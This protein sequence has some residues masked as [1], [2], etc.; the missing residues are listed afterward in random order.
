VDA[1][2]EFLEGHNG[3]VVADERDPAVYWITLHPQSDPE[4]T[5]VARLVWT[6]YPHSAPSVLFASSVGGEVGQARYWPIVPGYRPPNDICMPFTA[7]GLGLHT[8][9]SSGPQAW[10]VQGNPFVRVAQQLQDDLDN[11]YGGRAG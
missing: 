3:S 9:W 6:R 4:E 11:R 5:Y 8:E 1:V 10:I 2:K 7:E